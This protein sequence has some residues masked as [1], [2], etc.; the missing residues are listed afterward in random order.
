MSDETPD[1]IYDFAYRPAPGRLSP[2][3]AKKLLQPAGPA[4][5]DYERRHPKKPE[6]KFDM[7]KLVHRIVLGAGDEIAPVAGPDPKT[8]ELIRYG[9]YNTKAAQA[10]RDKAYADD[11]IPA[12]QHQIDTATEMA[13]V[14]YEHPEAGLLFSEGDAERWLY[15]TDPLTGQ[16]IRSR[17]DC[18]T[19]RD[20]LWII[21]FK[22]TG[23]KADRATFSRKA[24]DFGYYLQFAFS[25]AAARSLGRDDPVVVFVVQELAPPYL[26]N[27]LELDADYYRGAR[28]DM[29]RAIGIFR[30]CT[31][32][33][34]WPGYPL[35]IQPCSPPPYAFRTNSYADLD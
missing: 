11:M 6:P 16:P 10:I 21:D 3:G 20:R 15:G 28:D 12:L 9:N 34:V 24:Y 26:V 32:A 31:K 27:L 17:P 2:S 8:G 22:T 5:F 14:V 7:G 25:V 18:M 19:E 1:G 4:R 35:G 33:G 23:E 13:R 29:T 30:Q